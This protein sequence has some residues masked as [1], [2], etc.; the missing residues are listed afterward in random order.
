MSGNV[1]KEILPALPSLEKNALLPKRQSCFDIHIGSYQKNH[2]EIYVGHDR[3]LSDELPGARTC[4]TY[5][6]G[7]KWL[8]SRTVSENR[9]KFS[10]DRIISAP[11]MNTSDCFKLPELYYFPGLRIYHSDTVVNLLCNNILLT[12]SASETGLPMIIHSMHVFKSTEKTQDL[13]CHE[14]TL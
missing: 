12:E 11:V 1:Y 2:H 14:R 9:N 13:P 7:L 3:T 5:Y 4:G 10:G 6:S 8:F